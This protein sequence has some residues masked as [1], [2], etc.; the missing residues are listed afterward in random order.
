MNFKSYTPIPL[1]SLHP[2]NLPH[3]RGEKAS[4]GSR[5]VSRCVLRC[6][7]LPICLRLQVVTA[8]TH[9]SGP[10]PLAS[11]TLSIPGSHW[12]SSPVKPAPSCT[13]LMAQSPGCGSERYQGWSA[14]WLSCSYTLGAGP[15][16]TCTTRVS[17]TLLSRRGTGPV[18]PL[19]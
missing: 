13:P 18:L 14:C 6:I 1:I 11:A 3:Y 2:C 16:D 9:W 15:L 10:R 7:L 5:S 17:S 19:L 12:A 8:V 4:C